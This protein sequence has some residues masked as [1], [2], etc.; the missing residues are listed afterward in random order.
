MGNEN[1]GFAP[2]RA[3]GAIPQGPR[4]F[5]A[6]T[7]NFSALA[8]GVA[9]SSNITIESDSDFWCNAIT[10]QADIA[11]AILTE[12][13]NVIPLV[14]MQVTD[15][16]SGRNLVNTPTPITNWAGDG[17]RPFRF[18]HPRLFQRATSLAVTLTNYAVG[19]T[20]YNLRLT[21]LGFKVYGLNR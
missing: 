21:F 17:K 8:V 12:S 20:S 5:Y 9:Q 2:G 13:T 6:Y 14:T 15:V 16:G 3:N 7:V 10:Y 11:V 18:T 19:G 1:Q 4:D